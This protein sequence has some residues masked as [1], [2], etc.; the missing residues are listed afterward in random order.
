MEEL[1]SKSNINWKII[2]PGMLTN[3]TLTQSYGELTKLEKGMKVGKVSR[4]DVAHFIIGE[5]ENPKYLK[6]YVTL[7]N[8]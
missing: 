3:G 4:A 6:R 8:G 2:R 7:T 1:I 5:A